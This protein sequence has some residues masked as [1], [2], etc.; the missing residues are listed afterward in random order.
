MKYITPT[1]LLNPMHKISVAIIGCGGTGSQVLTGLARMNSTLI[2]LDHPGL[3]V[4]CIDD[5]VV[6]EANLGRQLFSASDIGRYKTDV[7]IERINRFYGINWQSVTKRIDRT[8]ALPY[9]IVISCVDSIESRKVIKDVMV[10]DL[11]KQPHQDDFEKQYYWLDFG[12]GNNSGQVILSDGKK[13][14]DIFILFPDFINQK[15]EEDAPSCS[16]AESIKKQDLYINGTLAMLGCDLLWKLFHDG[17]LE[18]QGLFLNLQ[19]L[20]VKPIKIK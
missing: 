7:L 2:A 20:T 8:Y 18:Y 14:K 9:N 15:S 17:S 1:Y 5:D 6:T 10:L 12:N 3:Q 16:V 13:L 19:T 4:T 11:K